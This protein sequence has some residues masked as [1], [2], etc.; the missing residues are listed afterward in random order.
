[1]QGPGAAGL[2]CG[3]GR[4]RQPVGG[5]A[6]ACG[7][8]G[9]HARAARR[10]RRLLVPPPIPLPL[11]SSSSTERRHGQL[12]LGHWLQ[13]CS[14][15]C[16]C[17][18]P[19]A[20]KGNQE[21]RVTSFLLC[22]GPGTGGGRSQTGSARGRCTRRPTWGRRTSTWGTCTSTAP[23]CRRCAAR[24]DPDSLLARLRCPRTELGSHQAV[25]Q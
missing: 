22:A 13:S 23:A 7:A 12:G 19:R 21:D 15:T 16:A 18:C 20:G 8:A 11:A 2:F 5:A 14:T 4:G 25:Q 9:A 1:M 3:G 6:P 17:C 10:R 24:S